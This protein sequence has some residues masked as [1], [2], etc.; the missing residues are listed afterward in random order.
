M[1]NNNTINCLIVIYYDLYTLIFKFF[2]KKIEYL[3]Y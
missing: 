1:K 2:N 3:T